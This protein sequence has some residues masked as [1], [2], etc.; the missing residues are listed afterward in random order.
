MAKVDYL[1]ALVE[2]NHK[3]KMAEQMET[4]KETKLIHLYDY[5]VQNGLEANW[6]PKT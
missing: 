5:A 6:V 1:Y 3:L 2:R 4:Y